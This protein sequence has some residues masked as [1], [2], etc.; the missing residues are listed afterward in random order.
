[1]TATETAEITAEATPEVTD[2][3][4]VAGSPDAATPA[5]GGTP[6]E[7]D[8]TPEQPARGLTIEAVIG[9]LGVIA[10]LAYV[11]L[12]L[13]G[14][15][16][17]ER[18][19]DGFVIDECPVCQRGQLTVDDRQ[20][21]MLGIPR[22]RRIVRCDV[23]RSVLREVGSR[24]WRY[25]VDPIENPPMYQRFNG[26]E[27]DEE[28]LMMLSERPIPPDGSVPDEPLTPPSFVDEDG[29]NQS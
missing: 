13:R 4:L 23:C 16:A 8:L 20:T 3:A 1:M 17:M 15:S 11:A 7:P 10:V 6:P 18:Y 22:P 25:A 29:D 28:V 21:R 9:A 14:M 24:R 12:Y 5:P 26:R 19:S 27:I 2:E